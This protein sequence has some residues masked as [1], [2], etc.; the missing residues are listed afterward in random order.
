MVSSSNLS[1][2]K[3]NTKS[4]QKIQQQIKKKKYIKTQ[5]KYKKK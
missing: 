3:K 2:L 1:N 5:K 4:P